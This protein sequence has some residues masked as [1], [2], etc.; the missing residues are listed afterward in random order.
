MGRFIFIFFL[1][2]LTASTCEKT[3]NRCDTAN[4]IGMDYRKCASPFCGGWYIEIEGDTL[5]F[6]EQPAKTDIEFSGEMAYPVPV[7]IVWRRYE[8]EWKDV[9]DLI[10]LEEA[11]LR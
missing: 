6:L 5:R 7:K 2:G 9:Q 10:F 3:G 11:Y 8:N 1:L 4:I